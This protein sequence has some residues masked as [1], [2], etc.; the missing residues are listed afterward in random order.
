MTDRTIT[1]IPPV[2]KNIA[3][4]PDSPGNHV[5]GEPGVWILLFGEMSF[6]A[7][8]FASFLYYRSFDP[9]GFAEAQTQLNQ[10]VGLVN[11]LLLLTSSLFVANA[12]RA[13]RAADTV[14]APRLFACGIAC[15]V[16]FI[17]CKGFEYHE[18]FDQGIA[19]SDHP[20][21]SFYFGLTVLHL[22]HVTIGTILLGLMTAATRRP[23]AKPVHYAMVESGACF[24]HMV[25]LLWIVIFALLY[26]VE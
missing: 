1:T 14:L 12:V 13:T 26:L 2:G 10:T 16:G 20:F 17:L 5:P 24:W 19:I 21:Y 23:L 8:L 25:D 22:G 7:S 3:T 4:G 9:A 15:A 6:F 11:T 18:L